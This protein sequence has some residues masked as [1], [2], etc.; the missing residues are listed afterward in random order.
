MRWKNEELTTSGNEVRAREGKRR[1]G[2]GHEGSE[3]DDQVR[4]AKVRLAQ[5]KDPLKIVF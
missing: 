5:K 2:F 1:E 4:K 3:G